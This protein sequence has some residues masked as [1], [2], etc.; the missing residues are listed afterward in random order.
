MGIVV[1]TLE[2]GCG[3]VDIG[4]R[5]WKFEYWDGGSGHV[6]IKVEGVALWTFYRGTSEWGYG[7][8][9]GGLGISVRVCKCGH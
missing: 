6:N 8:M 5:V 2:C 4:V 7:Y 1:W 3:H 9:V